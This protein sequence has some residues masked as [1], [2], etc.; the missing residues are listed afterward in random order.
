[1]R[2]RAVLLVACALTAACGRD[3]ADREYFAVLAM[4]KTESAPIATRIP[5]FDHAIALAPG[6]VAYWEKRGEYRASAG[7]L[8]GA[9][10]DLDRA[11]VLADRPYLRFV[12]GL[13]RCR[14]G[15]CAESLADL[16]QA[17]AAQPENAQLYRGR[18]LARSRAGQPEAAL[19]DAERL[20]ALAPANA[21]HRYVRGAAL[22]A[23]DRCAEAIADFDETLRARPELVFPLAARAACHE[24]LGHADEAASDRAAARARTDAGSGCGVCFDPL[25]F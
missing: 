11:I 8:P 25:H 23:L 20:L 21:E 6:R 12:R 17:I 16:D 5:H 10:S 15:R 22:A 24:R 9:E 7:D 13:I 4:E 3:A 19:A 1:M 2:I 18:A 14:A